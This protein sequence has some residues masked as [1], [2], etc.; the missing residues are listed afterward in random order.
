MNQ[1]QKEI[2][3]KIRAEQIKHFQDTRNA[4]LFIKPYPMETAREIA[5]FQL[6]NDLESG[7][8]RITLDELL[9][10]DDETCIT[11]ISNRQIEMVKN[12]IK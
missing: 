11:I 9:T 2:Y 7:F 8:L 1:Q 3:L 10:N 4:N 12:L 5:E 6:E